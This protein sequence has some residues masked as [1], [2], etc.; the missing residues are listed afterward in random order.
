MY[1]VV[2]KDPSDKRIDEMCT[3]C[4]KNQF[5]LEKFTVTEYSDPSL[6]YMYLAEFLFTNEQDAL[7]FRIMFS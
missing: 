2:I 4:Y 1:K 6:A 3:Y 5:S 7:L